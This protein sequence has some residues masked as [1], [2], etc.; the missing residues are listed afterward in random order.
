MTV[1]SALILVMWG[2]I[3]FGGQKPPEQTGAV[4]ERGK[5]DRVLLFLVDG[6]LKRYAHY[7]GNK[8]PEHLSGLVPKYFQI[9]KDRISF[10]DRLSYERDPNPEVG[11]RLSI[12]QTKAG[13]MK[14]ILTAKGLKY[15]QPSGE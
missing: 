7:E 5:A 8:F 15:I 4:M 9:S 6:S 13:A 14:V 10:L 3:F 12:A 1:S 2:V 11:Y